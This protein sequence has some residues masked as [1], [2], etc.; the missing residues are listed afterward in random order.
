MFK[1]NFTK[2]KLKFSKFLIFIIN[3]KNATELMG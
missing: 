1:K 3:G 2:M